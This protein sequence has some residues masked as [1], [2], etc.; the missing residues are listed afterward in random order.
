LPEGLPLGHG[1][2]K[3]VDAIG[4]GYVADPPARPE[5]RASMSG[6]LHFGGG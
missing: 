2:A 6:A 3:I 4:G 5:I 1:A